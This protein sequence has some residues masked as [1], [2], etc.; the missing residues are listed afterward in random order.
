TASLLR[1]KKT[2]Q[3]PAAH[4]VTRPSLKICPDMKN[5][6]L[7]LSSLLAACAAAPAMAQQNT[8]KLGLSNVQPHATASEFSGP[9]TPTGISID[10]LDKNTLFFSYTREINAHWGVELA[11]GLPPTHDI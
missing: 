3:L 9:F 4:C 2:C 11:L 5:K 6:K 1:P 10:V 7:L 8:I